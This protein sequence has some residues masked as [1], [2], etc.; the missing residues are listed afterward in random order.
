MITDEQLKEWRALIAALEAARAENGARQEIID[1]YRENYDALRARLAEIRE[2]A[3]P[4]IEFGK[5][6]DAGAGEPQNW[7]INLTD[8][9]ARLTASDLRA[10][11][12]AIGKETA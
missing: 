9:G 6:T 11:A 3:K 7:Q 8:S 10:L 2:A 12:D 4:I 1:A 5:A